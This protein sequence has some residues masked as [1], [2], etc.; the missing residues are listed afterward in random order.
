MTV[1]AMPVRSKIAS[2]DPRKFV[3]PYDVTHELMENRE[4]FIGKEWLTLCGF[5]S[6]LHTSLDRVRRR[7]KSTTKPGLS[8]TAA[9]CITHGLQA[10]SGHEDVQ[11]LLTLKAQL[12]TLDGVAADY[13][14]AIS[15]WF[16]SFP[17]GAPNASMSGSRKQNI[18]L[19]EQLKQDI[20]EL[21]GELGLTSTALATL[22]MTA[23]LASQ[24]A[25]LAGHARDCVQAVEIFLKHVHLRRRL[26]EVL[27]DTLRETA[28]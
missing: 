4:E 3:P 24:P 12:D 16:R 28:S 13:A 6:Y 10:I 2:M 9:C 17:I 14:D 21:G 15:A 23:T 19:P 1:V 11:G 8:P 20:H 22:A 18:T 25:V 26:G 27:V 7:V 5:P